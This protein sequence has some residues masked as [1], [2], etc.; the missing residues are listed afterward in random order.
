MSSASERAVFVLDLDASRAE[1]EL[2]RFRGRMPV[3]AD[4]LERGGLGL[5]GFQER[6]EKSATAISGFGSVMHGTGAQAGAFFGAVSNISTAFIAGGPLLVGVVAVTTGVSYLAEAFGDAKKKADEARQ[7]AGEAINALADQIAK[8]NENLEKRV[9]EGLFGKGGSFVKGMEQLKQ[10]ARGLQREIAELTNEGAV[11]WS[12]KVGVTV[13]RQEAWLAQIKEL[14]LRLEEK[15]LAIIAASDEM[16]RYNELSG[17]AA[18]FDQREKN[19]ADKLREALSKLKAERK[20][21]AAE[22]ILVEG[23]GTE[24]DAWLSQAMDRQAEISAF[25]EAEAAADAQMFDAWLSA[26]MSKQ[27]DLAKAKQNL[28][29]K[30]FADASRAAV[31]AKEREEE[32]KLKLAE[33]AARKEADFKMRLVN[34]VTSFASSAAMSAFGSFLD[35]VEDAAAGQEIAFAKVASAFI[36]NMG[37]QIMGIGIRYTAEGAGALASALI[38]GQ[39]ANAAGGAAMLALGLAATSVGGGMALTGAVSSGLAA[40]MSGGGGGGGG[41]GGRGGVRPTVGTVG[42]RGGS[43][44]AVGQEPGSLTIVFNGGTHLGDSTERARTL[45]RDHQRASRNI[46]LP[47]GP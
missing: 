18:K 34:D 15:Q 39:Q 17:L 31:A 11:G 33:D 45:R 12:E 24:F 9:A 26:S 29:E 19:A 4:Q 27:E 3:F 37:M 22:T 32:D 8:E 5:K 46:Y 14:E 16:E 13:N 20:A 44:R 1:Q 36:K 43:D 6:V 40:R 7:A 23:E 28:L 30:M 25:R 10:E 41:A 38:P 42:S 35:V 2:S 21:L 47:G